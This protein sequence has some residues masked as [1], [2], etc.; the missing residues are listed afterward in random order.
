MASTKP[1]SLPLRVTEGTTA[2]CRIYPRH[3]NTSTSHQQLLSWMLRACTRN[4]SLQRCER[5]RKIDGLIVASGPWL[6]HCKQAMALL[7]VMAW[8]DGG[9]QWRQGFLVKWLTTATT[10][11]LIT[12]V[13]E[14]L[15]NKYDNFLLNKECINRNP[16]KVV[17]A[18]KVKK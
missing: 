9:L 12:N 13:I 15:T 7:M 11:I 1:P 8:T 18:R 16:G 10:T 6:Q 3:G 4:Q 14:L 17:L 2:I 5:A